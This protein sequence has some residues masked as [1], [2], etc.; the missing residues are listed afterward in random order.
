MDEEYTDQGSQNILTPD[1]VQEL[2]EE[3]RDRWVT[4]IKS[5]WGKHNSYTYRWLIKKV[6][7]G[8]WNVLRHWDYTIEDRY[9]DIAPRIWL[10][11]YKGPVKDD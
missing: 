4:E 10:Q 11:S 9:G 3:I 7:D 6:E 8:M 2:A 1:Q 5:R